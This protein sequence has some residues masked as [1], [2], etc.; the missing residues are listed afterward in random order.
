MRKTV[1]TQCRMLTKIKV[2]DIHHRSTVS[3]EITCLLY[4]WNFIVVFPFS[5]GTVGG[6]RFNA[7]ESSCNPTTVFI[8]LLLLCKVHLLNVS[9]DDSRLS[10]SF[11]NICNSN[12]IGQGSRGGGDQQGWWKEGSVNFKQRW[13]WILILAYP[14]I[15][16][17]LKFVSFCTPRFKL[18]LNS[19]FA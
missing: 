18:K 11:Y 2:Q 15:C 4:K 9:L 1:E 13:F 14:C 8:N 16:H 17:D 10:D 7:S 19:L 5:R 6:F 3:K 12:E